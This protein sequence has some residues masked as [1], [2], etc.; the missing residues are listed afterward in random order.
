MFVEIS[1]LC[2][3][4]VDPD[5]MPHYVASDLGLH[6][7]PVSFYGMLGLNGLNMVYVTRWN[8]CKFTDIEYKEHDSQDFWHIY[9]ILCLVCVQ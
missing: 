9:F 5:Q 2:A 1:E 8:I 3:N 6:C 4:S 7:L